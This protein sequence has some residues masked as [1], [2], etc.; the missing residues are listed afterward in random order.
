MIGVAY[1]EPSTTPRRLLLRRLRRENLQPKAAA[2]LM[3]EWDFGSASRAMNGLGPLDLNRV[4]CLPTPILRKF[5][6]DLI[7]AV[8]DR[9][10]QADERKSA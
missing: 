1:V 5:L 9:E 4:W 6:Y 3:A 10:E 8:V 7:R 2:L